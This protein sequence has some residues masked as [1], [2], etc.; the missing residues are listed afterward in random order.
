MPAAMS[1]ADAILA[2][3]QA[4]AERRRLELDADPTVER[5]DFVL[6]RDRRQGGWRVQFRKSCEPV[7]LTDGRLL[8]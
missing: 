8:E 1:R 6:L 5:V 2:A 7:G 4:E 3:V